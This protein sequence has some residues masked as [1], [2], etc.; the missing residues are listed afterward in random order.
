MSR[1]SGK[2]GSPTRR[3]AIVSPFVVSVRVT[4]VRVAVRPAAAV[5]SLSSYIDQPWRVGKSFFGA[6][7][8]ADDAR[9]VTWRMRRRLAEACGRGPPRLF[10]GRKPGGGTYGEPFVQASQEKPERPAASCHCSKPYLSE[11]PPCLSPSAGLR[12]P[13]AEPRPC[14]LNSPPLSSSQ[15]SRC[16]LCR[17]HTCR[18]TSSRSQ[19][20]QQH[21]KSTSRQLAR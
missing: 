12:V 4:G 5:C 13:G 20:D 10:A 9:R 3:A 15:V 18:V 19:R 11:L 2:L 21:R 6:F 7:D 8:R 14:P 17:R 16:P 1:L